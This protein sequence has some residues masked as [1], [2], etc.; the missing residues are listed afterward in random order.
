VVIGAVTLRGPTGAPA[1]ARQYAAALRARLQRVLALTP[2]ER[3]LGGIR[4]DGTFSKA[5]AL[6]AFSMAYSPLP[7]VKLPRGAAGGTFEGTMAALMVRRFRGQL[8]NAQQTAIDR[9]TAPHR[10]TDGRARIRVP[11][12]TFTTDRAA[13]AMAQK[14]LGYYA[15]RMPGV[16]AAMPLVVGDVSQEITVKGGGKALAVTHAVNPQYVTVPQLDLGRGDHCQIQITPTGVGTRGTPDFETTIAH[17]TFHCVQF[18][19]ANLDNLP[20]WIVEGGAEWAAQVAHPTSLDDSGLFYVAY[21]LDPRTSVLAR[22]YDAIG[23]WAHADELAGGAGA[24]FARMPDILRAT[25]ANAFA[26][27][28]GT[29]G[30]FVDTWASAMRRLPG[31]GLA[32][33]QGLPYVAPEGTSYRGQPLTSPAVPVTVSTTLSA[34]AYTT[35]LYDVAGQP[36]KPLITF[37]AASGSTRAASSGTDFGVLGTNGFCTGDCTC[38]DGVEPTKPIPPFSQIDGDGLKL[39][40]SGGAA[41]ASARVT[42]H[43]MKEYCDE[44]EPPDA[45]HLIVPGRSVGAVRIGMSRATVEKLLTPARGWSAP[46]ST[47]GTTASSLTY[48]ELDHPAGLLIVSFYGKGNAGRAISIVVSSNAFATSSNVGPGRPLTALKARYSVSCYHRDGEERNPHIEDN[49]NK[50]CELVTAGAFGPNPLPGQPSSPH[51]TYFGI[52]S[53]DA[54]PAQSIGAVSVSSV[55]I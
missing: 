28:G 50:S 13:L 47:T 55:R 25:N 26:L 18:Q 11:A 30:Q 6:R 37:S 29:S 38:P 34:P 33:M 10:L 14:Y 7:G 35:R 43:A 22:N 32:W 46:R 51:Y 31:R 23:F 17:E 54:D 21:L 41:A 19:L 2:W 20:E 9:A 36:A 1:G 24:L 48:S 45:N 16:S 42:F 39:G 3:N 12:V 5:L 15:A 49:D 53:V 4:A 27:A 44:P 52:A 40:Q 8:T